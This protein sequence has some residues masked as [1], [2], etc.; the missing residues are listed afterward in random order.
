MSAEDN[1]QFPQEN[2]GGLDFSK[3]GEELYKSLLGF[4]TEFKSVAFDKEIARKVGKPTKYASLSAI[5]KEIRPILAKNGLFIMQPL[6]IDRLTTRIQHVS[7]QY[8]QSSI[9]FQSMSST[10]GSINN[11]QKM[12]GGFTYLKRYAISAVLGIATEEDN[13]G[14]GSQLEVQNDNKKE[15]QKPVKTSKE[16]PAASKEQK[17]IIRTLIT[18]ASKIQN[19]TAA[20]KK[21]FEGF[22]DDLNQHQK[23]STLTPVLATNYIK[24]IKE[25]INHYKK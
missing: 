13:D 9:M 14:E 17:D 7:G 22:K 25:F 16:V 1:L 20:H 15:P 4:H 10:Q 12:G 18:K 19:L 6:C 21:E 24:K 2:I 23:D 8:I 11:L 3:A 5:L